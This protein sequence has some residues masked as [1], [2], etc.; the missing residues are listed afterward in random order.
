[1]RPLHWHNIKARQLIIPFFCVYYFLALIQ[2]WVLAEWKMPTLGPFTHKYRSLAR[3]FFFEC[4]HPEHPEA[5]SWNWAQVFQKP[6]FQ[7]RFLVPP[8]LAITVKGHSESTTIKVCQGNLGSECDESVC[9]FKHP[10]RSVNSKTY[11]LG[12]LGKTSLYI[13]LAYHHNITISS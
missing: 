2:L 1:M 11:S 4:Q 13:I 9:F 8:A 7:C 10:D 12:L 5:W 3:W 6:F